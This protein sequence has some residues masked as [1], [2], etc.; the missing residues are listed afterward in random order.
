MSARGP[1]EL[2]VTRTRVSSAQKRRL[3]CSNHAPATLFPLAGMGTN[4]D[5]HYSLTNE[6][7]EILN[8]ARQGGAAGSVGTPIVHC[9][10]PIVLGST[11]A[12]GTPPVM[13][14]NRTTLVPIGSGGDS[15]GRQPGCTQLPMLKCGGRSW[16]GFADRRSVHD[17]RSPVTVSL[18]PV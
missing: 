8:A 18:S 11:E 14:A 4:E 9:R 12:S 3:A 7:S 13:S 5:G 17:P 6:T 10:A 2:A 16:V 1:D 15:G